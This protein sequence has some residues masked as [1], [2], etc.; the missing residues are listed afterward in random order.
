MSTD[1]DL[2]AILE[3]LRPTLN[4]IKK[5]YYYLELSDDTYEN[6]F[7][8]NL[9]N[10]KQEGKLYRKDLK[11]Y[12]KYT[13]TILLFDELKKNCDIKT[14]ILKFINS[15]I[16]LKSNKKDNKNE[17]LKLSKFLNKIKL[18]FDIEI[19]QELLDKSSIL[20]GIIENL[21]PV[22]EINQEEL[23]NITED[24]NIFALLETYCIHHNIK[25]IEDEMDNKF[26]EA[27][28]KSY[29][30]DSVRMYLNE[31]GRIKRLTREDEIYYG[32]LLKEGNMEAKNI[33]IEANLRL[34]VSVAK[35][36]IGKGLLFVDLIQEGNIGLMKAVDRFD[37]TKGYKFSTYA[38][39]WIRQAITRALFNKARTIRIPVHMAEKYKKIGMVS[40]KLKNKLKREPTMEEIAKEMH[41]SQKKLEEI[42]NYFLD[43]ASLDDKVPDNEE[44]LLG[45]VIPD[46]KQHVEDDAVTLFFKEH[47][48]NL[49]N[50]TNLNENERLVLEFR[51]GLKN[52]DCLSLG[53]IGKIIGITRERTRQIEAKALF[54]LRCNPVISNFASYM[55]NPEEAMEKVLEI[56]KLKGNNQKIYSN[57]NIMEKFETK[58]K[59]EI[60]NSKKNDLVEKSTPSIPVQEKTEKKSLL[61][62]FQ[63]EKENLSEVM[64]TEKPKAFVKKK[65]IQ[66]K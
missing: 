64:Q 26:Y 11:K 19:F 3:E 62:Y 32:M 9:E 66:K 40:L 50:T 4:I 42:Q 13:F 43:I 1:N 23:F 41:I 65:V 5:T 44:L 35:R 46:S 14:L 51:F 61:S 48:A 22:D 15:N 6:L 38:T 21:L 7:I 18:E 31:I 28:D 37:P 59:K 57:G 34:V 27:I 55:D 53:E 54:K 36:Y 8:Q 45:S 12:F 39:W 47:V 63:I 49:L 2:K 56:R 10:I 58:D 25:I 20:N 16:E 24:N 30:S 60:S 29:S 33:F 52:N 17:L